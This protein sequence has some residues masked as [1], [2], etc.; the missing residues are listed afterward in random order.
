MWE[1][2]QRGERGVKM[3]TGVWGG[4]GTFYAKGRADFS[5]LFKPDNVRAVMYVS[6]AYAVRTGSQE[7]GPLC[8]YNASGHHYDRGSYSGIVRLVL[9]D[10]EVIATGLKVRP[11][12]THGHRHDS[13]RVFF[14]TGDGRLHNVVQ[15]FP[16][17]FI[18]ASR[19][20]HGW[21]PYPERYFP[22]HCKLAKL[23]MNTPVVIDYCRDR[24][25]QRQNTYVQLMDHRVLLGIRAED[26]L[27]CLPEP[28]HYF[29]LVWS[30]LECALWMHGW[31][32]QLQQLGMLGITPEEGHPDNFSGTMPDNVTNQFAKMHS[33]HVVAP[34][35]SV[36]TST[37]QDLECVYVHD[38]ATFTMIKRQGCITNAAELR[39]NPADPRRPFMLKVDETDIFTKHHTS[40]HNTN[41]ETFPRKVAVSISWMLEHYHPEVITMAMNQ[42]WRPHDFA[43]NNVSGGLPLYVPD[44]DANHFTWLYGKWAILQDDVGAL[45]GDEELG[46]A[47]KSM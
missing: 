15:G 44:D 16:L 28:H 4:S 11:E 5:E 14:Q 22:D 39:Y 43:P 18:E 26:N 34:V 35:Y 45:P 33:A 46:C 24:K 20:K 37:V 40:R 12:V 9:D 23:C 38:A 21:K 36:N 32:M 19:K 25:P 8:E 30:Y 17:M 2:S 10:A 42:V 27:V 29:S 1:T 31:R 13:W 47:R 3:S 6:S 7:M 41:K